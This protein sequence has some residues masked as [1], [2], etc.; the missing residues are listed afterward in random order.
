MPV[1]PVLVPV[2]PAG[3]VPGCGV[4]VPGDG[5][6][7]A[8]DGELGDFNVGRSTPV[9]G[10]GVAGV[11]GLSAGSGP[12]GFGMGGHES[13]ICCNH[14]TVR[15]PSSPCPVTTGFYPRGDNLRITSR[16]GI[17]D[18]GCRVYRVIEGQK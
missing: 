13:M 1:R 3:A 18:T 7:G 15:F 5:D 17:A 11:G 6:A 16:L 8:G 2:T 10:V 14:P 9:A 12:I 4:G